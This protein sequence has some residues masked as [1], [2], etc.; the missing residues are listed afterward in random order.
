MYE[1]LNFIAIEVRVP[2]INGETKR[3][4]LEEYFQYA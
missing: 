4:V 1:V 3:G 2:I